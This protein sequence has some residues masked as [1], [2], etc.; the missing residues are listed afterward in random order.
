MEQIERNAT[1]EGVPKKVETTWSTTA[2]KLSMLSFCGILVLDR[3]VVWQ[4]FFSGWTELR[5]RQHANL[6]V[7]EYFCECPHYQ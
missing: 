6:H 4:F 2:G 7:H 3:N 1:K 5:R